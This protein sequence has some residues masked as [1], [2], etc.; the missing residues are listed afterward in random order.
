MKRNILLNPGPA[1]TTDTVKNAQVVPDICPR[2]KEFGEV[3]EFV[4][5]ELT[6]LVADNDEYTTVLFGGSGTAAVE[7]MISSVVDKDILLIINNGAYGKRICEMAEIYDLNF[8]E[9]IGSPVNGIDFIKLEQIISEYNTKKR[10]IKNKLNDYKGIVGRYNIKNEDDEIKV[11][12]H[13]AVI[14]HETTT[15]ILN[16]IHRV[17]GLC[18]KYN[19][20]LIVDGMSSFA[21][22]PIDMKSSNIKCLASS[23]NKCIQGMAGVSFVIAEKE[24]LINTKRIKPRNLYLNLYNQYEYFQKNYQMRFTP[25]VQVLYALKQA[26]IETKAETIERRYERYVR[27]CEILWDGLEKLNLKLLVPKE[28]S[29]MLLTSIVEPEVKGYNF[30]SLHNYLYEKGFTIY[31]GKVSSKNT[32]RIANI[33]DIYPENMRKFIEILEEYFLSIK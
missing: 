31:P 21:G 20:D 15:G 8:I 10:F 11:I 5:K 28:K 12:S 18:S 16:D 13:I 1:T 6:N 22:I 7:S 27:C 26:I 19:I 29:S 33:G 3:M 2:E 9:F 4:S 23:S 24:L 17:G 25:P 30:D 14:H 32:F